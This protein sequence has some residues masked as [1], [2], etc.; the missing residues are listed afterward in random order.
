MLISVQ[1]P[2]GSNPDKVEITVQQVEEVTLKALKITEVALEEFIRK[3]VQVL[4]PEGETLLIV[5]QQLRNKAGGRADLVAVDGEGGIVLIELKRDLGDIVAR[6]EPFEFQAIRYAASYALIETPQDLVQKLY[7]PYIE[8]HKGEFE[9]EPLT[10]SELAARK[11]TEFLQANGAEASFNRRQSIVLI[12]SA[13]DPQTL[14]ACAWLAKNKI[15][16]RCLRLAPVRH[17]KN[18]YFVFEQLIPP[19]TLEEYFVELAEQPSRSVPASKSKQP[20]EYLLPKMPQLF[21]WHLITQGDKIYVKDREAQVATALDKNYVCFE[22][23]KLTYNDWGK[24]VTGWSGINVYVQTVH[25]PTGKTLDVLRK[26]KMQELQEIG[27]SQ[28]TGANGDSQGT[29]LDPPEG[30]D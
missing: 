6:K 25:E 17:N 1:L 5:G 24:K 27:T 16:I 13:F 11:L 21:E 4:Y 3:N 19:R 23:Q 2:G 30:G 26:E 14:S 9:L 22:G 15:D 12:A 7:A 10:A 29:T 20:S 18:V 28:D 8:K